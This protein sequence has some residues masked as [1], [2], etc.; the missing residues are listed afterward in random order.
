MTPEERTENVVIVVKE[1][2]DPRDPQ[3]YVD[4]DATAENIAA[5]IREAV[6]EERARIVEMVRNFSAWDEERDEARYPGLA[7]WEGD[8]DDGRWV[9][10]PDVLAKL[11]EGPT[12]GK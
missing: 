10:D 7:E 11:I 8:D 4:S 3:N 5:A 1:V 6:A 2:G 12:P 9:I